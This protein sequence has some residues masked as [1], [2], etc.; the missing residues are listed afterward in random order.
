M[1][2]AYS[3]EDWDAGDLENDSDYRESPVAK[4]K[5]KA[6]KARAAAKK[7]TKGK[8]AK[9]TKGK[10]KAGEKKAL[11]V[12]QIENATSSSQDA[13]EFFDGEEEEEEEEGFEAKKKKR[14]SVERLYQKKSQK[15]HILLRPDT[16]IGSTERREEEM[17]VLDVAAFE[18]GKAEAAK[19]KEDPNGDADGDDDDDEDWCAEDSSKS[20]KKQKNGKGKGSSSP[21]SSLP[22]AEYVRFVNR[23]ISFVPGLYK[24]FDEILVNAA[25]HKQRDTKG[26]TQLRVEVDRT[27]GRISVHNNGKG[28]PV[29]MH[30]EHGVYVPELIFGHLLSGSNFDDGQKKVTGGR[31]GFGAKLTNIFSLEFTIETSCAA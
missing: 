11:G 23:T 12:S 9:A 8:K 30:K 14:L 2:S 21:S 10:G 5:T 27:T 17:W 19:A 7:T 24:I 6:T 3:D 29:E 25:D 28:I 20:K 15:E 13:D 31:N 26:M 16:Y 18:K 22:G 4:R 1:S